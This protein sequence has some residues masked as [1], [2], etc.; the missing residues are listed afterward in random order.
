MNDTGLALIMCNFND[1]APLTDLMDHVFSGT[2]LPDEIIVVDDCSTD[3][4][5][6][7]IKSLQKKYSGR[8]QIQLL[9]TEKRRGP[10]PAFIK[11]VKAAQSPFIA[12]LSCNDD[13]LKDYT[14]RMKQAIQ[15]YPQVDAFLCNAIVEREGEEYKKIFFPRD[16]FLSPEDMVK[17]YKNNNPSFINMI[18]MVLRKD[19]ILRCWEEGG[20][21][22]PACFDG[23]SLYQTAFDKGMVVLGDCL[24]CYHASFSGWGVTRGYERNKESQKK[25]MAMLDK[26]PHL[27][28]RVAQTKIWSVGTL[29]KASFGLWIVPKLPKWM[30]KRIYKKYYEQTCRFDKIKAN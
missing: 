8:K 9:K 20:K 30:R 24:V 23:M 2:M 10:C 26:Y 1:S 14:Q 16:I 28:E 25:I 6:E 22:L 15:D 17:I 4:S 29:N 18:G 12:S 21:D 7:K 27:K 5:V 19:V 11:G 13:M 3:D